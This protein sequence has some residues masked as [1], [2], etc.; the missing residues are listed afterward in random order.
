[1]VIPDDLKYTSE[2]EWLRLEGEQAVVGITDHAQEKLGDIT[3]I[4]LPEVGATFRAGEN[5]AA[6]ESVK[7]AGD[8]YAPV[9]GDVIAVNESLND[10]PENV[11]SAP[12]E[13]GWIARFQIADTAELE[14]LM[15]AKAYQR[16]VEGSSE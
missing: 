12:Y 13:S 4:E 6:I 11:N 14:K 2:H 3:F 7:A 8:I 1:M 10:M 9:S 16:F 15:D 5:F